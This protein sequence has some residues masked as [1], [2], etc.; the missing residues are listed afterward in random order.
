MEVFKKLSF[1]LLMVAFVFGLI[2]PISVFAVTTSPVLVAS[3]GYSVLA[4]STVTN[5]GTTTVSGDLG[6][7]P[8]SAVTGSPT[9]TGTIH[10]GD[11]NAALAQIDNSAAFDTLDQGCT[12]TYGGVQNL[13]LVSPLAPGVYCATAFTLTGDLILSGSG[14]WIFKSAETL[15]TSSGSS[16]T[17]GDPCNIWWR[18][19]SS[20]TLNSTTVF[21]GNILALTSIALKTGATLNGRA[22]A[23]TGAVTLEG[24]TIS[25]PTCT[26]ATVGRSNMGTI[27]VVK[28]VINDN[29]GTKTIADFPL[30][31]NGTPIASGSTNTLFASSSKYA[32]TEITDPNYVGTFSGDCDADGVMYLHPGEDQFCILTNNDIGAPVTPPIPPLIDV[33]KVPSPLALP[34]GP[35][36]INYTYTLRNIGTVPVT[37]ITMVGDTCSPITLF[38]GDTNA[39]NKLEVSETWVYHC[40]TTLSETHTNTVVA[41]GWANGLSATDIASAT[42][43]V[44]LPTVPPLIHVTKLPKPLALSAKGGMV[45]YTEKITNPG[46]VALSNVTLTDDKCSPMKY[47]SG[48]TNADAKL[49]TTETW[50]YTCS[51]NLIATTTNTAVATGWANGLSVRDFAIATVT[52]ASVVPKLPNTG[53]F[54]EG[55][56][57]QLVAILA[58]ALI[59]AL[60]S[61]VVFLKKYKV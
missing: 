54:S 28:L 43:I 36:L 52:V 6:V 16:V 60:V 15:I 51:A 35:G 41:T 42:V 8:G 3:D 38:S 10:A 2:G 45:T 11:A 33:V 57:V 37:N 48:D 61:L 20:A 24:N 39:N 17:G 12:T 53:V 50:T 44:G 59:L 23:Q 22:M 32:V 18:V 49:D 4:G 34:T 19:G 29:G 14:V 26:G 27:N 46:T 47:I 5:T 1:I 58:S 7:S 40:G 25:G 55:N 56:G 21:K 30:F 13:T 31:I 9:V